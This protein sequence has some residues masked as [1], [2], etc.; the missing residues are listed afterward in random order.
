MYFHLLP[1]YNSHLIISQYLINN[2][3][4]KKILSINSLYNI[5]IIG[6]PTLD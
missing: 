4:R 1:I 5:G 6:I 3:L 2:V